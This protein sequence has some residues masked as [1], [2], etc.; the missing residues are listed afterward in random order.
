MESRM[1]KPDVYYQPDD[2][3]NSFIRNAVGSESQDVM[4]GCENRF[5][6]GLASR[7]LV[8]VKRELTMKFEATPALTSCIKHLAAPDNKRS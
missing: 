7:D 6:A 8:L 3:I 5:A 4:I 1:R 2:V